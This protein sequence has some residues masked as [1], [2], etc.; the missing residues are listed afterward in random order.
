MTNNLAD[1]IRAYNLWVNTFQVNPDTYVAWRQRDELWR[2]VSEVLG[3]ANEE[4]LGA[5]IK[6]WWIGHVE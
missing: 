1:E 4:E 6:S 3:D 5:I 2:L